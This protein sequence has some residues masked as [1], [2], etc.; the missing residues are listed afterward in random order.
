MSK[1]IPAAT[2]RRAAKG[3]PAG[4]SPNDEGIRGTTALGLLVL[5]PRRLGPGKGPRG[6]SGATAPAK[7]HKP[8]T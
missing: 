6:R 8:G 7:G 5:P 4:R 2:G 1:K 3:G